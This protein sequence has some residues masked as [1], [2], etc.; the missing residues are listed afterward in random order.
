M[1]TLAGSAFNLKDL[2]SELHQK[3]EQEKHSY[4]I[5]EVDDEGKDEP[6][7]AASSS[8]EDSDSGESE[9]NLDADQL[10]AILPKVRG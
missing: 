9:D 5:H 10:L 7:G 4:K 3:M 1:T 8:D 2:M 6:R